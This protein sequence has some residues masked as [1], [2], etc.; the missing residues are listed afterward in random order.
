MVLVKIACRN[1]RWMKVAP[2]IGVNFE[3]FDG[4]KFLFRGS[5][6]ISDFNGKLSFEVLFIGQKLS[7]R[8]SFRLVSLKCQLSARCNT[9]STTFIKEDQIQNIFH[10]I[11]RQG[12]GDIT[13]ETFYLVIAIILSLKEQNWHSSWNMKKILFSIV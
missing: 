5:R 6:F 11:D 4:Y 3:A 8:A 10:M 12:K 7:S 13:W 9:F 2:Q 1:Y